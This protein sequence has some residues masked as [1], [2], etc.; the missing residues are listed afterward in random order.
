MAL[1]ITDRLRILFLTSVLIEY[2]VLLY[3]L[4]NNQIEAPHITLFTFFLQHYI[5]TTLKQTFPHIVTLIS[6]FI[7]SYLFK[8]IHH[9]SSKTNIPTEDRSRIGDS[10]FSQWQTVVK[11]QLKAIYTAKNSSL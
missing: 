6:N 5:L 11:V 2:Q 8:H 9:C 10:L 3:V 1:H 7:Q 4:F